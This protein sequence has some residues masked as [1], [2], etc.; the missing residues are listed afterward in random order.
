MNENV[1][2]RVLAG[3]RCV[4]AIT[5]ASI[6]QP[7]SVDGSPLAIRRNTSGIFA[8]LD[9]PGLTA[10]T[11]KFLPPADGSWPLPTN[12]TITI[13]DPSLR[14]LPRRAQIAVPQP[15]PMTAPPGTTAPHTT[16][17]AAPP[18]P[19][20]V[21]TPQDIFL[22]PTPAAPL[23]PNWAVVR[24]SVASSSAPPVPLPWAVIQVTMSGSP[25]VNGVANNRG[26]ALTAVAGL[27][28]QLSASGTGAVT[29]TTTPATVTALFD[30][31]T[32]AQPKGWI[33]NPDDI[34]LN[35]SSTK[36]K[37]ASATVQ[38]A[39]GQTVFVNLTISM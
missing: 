24:A 10:L 32:L 15:L 21:T 13:Q 20:P 38:L 9:A 33:P 16:S 23:A 30:P 7:L 31:A 27:G 26:E 37:T 19:P 28:L 18:P 12:A 2:R 1:D 3:F 36:W 14:Y 8:V 6:L 11:T 5:G 25:P 22:Y 34:L 39:P 35:L 4:D 29:E 17:L